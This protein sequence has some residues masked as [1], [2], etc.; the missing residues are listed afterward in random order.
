MRKKKAVTI[1]L[2]TQIWDDY[3]RSSR[4]IGEIPSH[5]IERFLLMEL[6]KLQPIIKYEEDEKK[7]E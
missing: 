1:Y 3:V 4:I 6:W 5:K 2:D 7:N